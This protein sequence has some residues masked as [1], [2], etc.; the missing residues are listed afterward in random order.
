MNIENTQAL[1]MRFYNKEPTLYGA[2][3]VKFPPKLPSLKLLK[4]SKVSTF[5]QTESH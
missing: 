4:F 2:L 5:R 3:A 1:R